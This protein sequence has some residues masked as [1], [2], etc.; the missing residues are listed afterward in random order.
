MTTEATSTTADTVERIPY[1]DVLRSMN[2]HEEEKVEA[3][4][5]RDIDMLP[6]ARQLRALVFV[7][8]IRTGLD[9]IAAHQVVMGMTLQQ[10]LQEFSDTRTPTDEDAPAADPEPEPQA[11]EPAST[12]IPAPGFQPDYHAGPYSD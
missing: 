8:R 10:I 3:T 5:G 9:A 1:M 12:E 4:F 6:F 7:L 11:A 2:G